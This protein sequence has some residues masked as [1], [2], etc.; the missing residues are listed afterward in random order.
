[1]GRQTRID[2][3]KLIVLLDEIPVDAFTSTPMHAIGD[4]GRWFE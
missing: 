4:L 1:M 3:G 2:D